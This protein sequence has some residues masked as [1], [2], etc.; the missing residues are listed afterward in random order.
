MTLQE[1]FFIDRLNNRET[2]G[3]ITEYHNKKFPDINEYRQGQKLLSEIAEFQGTI[4]E[5][6]KIDEACDLII[7]AIGYISR[8]GRIPYDELIKKFEK[9]LERDYPDNFQHKGE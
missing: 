1:Q 7:S 4:T 9:V 2:I 5:N 3:L 8:C 6:E